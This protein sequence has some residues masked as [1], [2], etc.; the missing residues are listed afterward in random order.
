MFSVVI[1]KKEAFDSENWMVL[2]ELF[3]HDNCINLI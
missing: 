1:L 2:I 3:Y